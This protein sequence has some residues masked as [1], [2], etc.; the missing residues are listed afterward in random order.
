MYDLVKSLH[1]I[2][3]IVFIGGVLLLSVV[4]PTGAREVL[5]V[6]RRWD[7]HVT[8]SALLMVWLTGLCIALEGHWINQRW[9][10]L[11]LVLV[12]ILSML[13]GILAGTARRLINDPEQTL[14]QQFRYAPAAAIVISAAVICLAVFR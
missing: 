11:K 13:H 4:L 2:S 1:I 7:Y 6:A 3:I 14:I 8:S 12:V 10:H 9:L 5:H